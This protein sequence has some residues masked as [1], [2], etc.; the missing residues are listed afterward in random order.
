ME[1]KVPRAAQVA[2]RWLR[3]VALERLGHIDDA[4]QAFQSAE[5]LPNTDWA[6]ALF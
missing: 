2:Y 4:E 3:G 1:Q 6:P 5:S